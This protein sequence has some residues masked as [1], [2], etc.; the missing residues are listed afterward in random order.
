MKIKVCGMRE[1]KNIRLVSSLEPDYMGF[2]FYK[3]S[4]RYVGKNFITPEI[5]KSVEKVGVFVNQKFQQ[6]IDLA[7]IY[8]IGTL[9]LHGDESPQLC[10][11]LREQFTIIKAFSMDENFDFKILDKYQNVVDYFLFDAKGLGYGGNGT[12]FDWNLLEAYD[13]EIPLILSGG[14]GLHNLNNLLEFIKKT[15][16]NVAA[17]DVNS[18][19][20]IS[21]GLKDI[22]K[23]KTAINLIKTNK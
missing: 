2:I 23:I 11:N 19:F 18:S 12:S 10:D 7:G 14:I 9:Q 15:S 3:N 20:E 22:Q 1:P 13:N 8:Q 6:V 16:L 21:P 4:K 5:S 17:I